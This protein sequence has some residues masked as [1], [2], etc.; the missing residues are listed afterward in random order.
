MINNYYKLGQGENGNNAKNEDDIDKF[1][2][3]SSSE[4]EDE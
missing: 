3:L 2:N 4:D 1:M